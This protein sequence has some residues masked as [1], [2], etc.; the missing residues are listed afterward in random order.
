MLIKN[1]L[2]KVVLSV[3][4][5]LCH[6]KSYSIV[7]Y[8]PQSLRECVA[9]VYEKVGA[10]NSHQALAEL[11]AAIRENRMLTSDSVVSQGVQEALAI[12][13]SSKSSDHN[14]MAQYFEKLN[15][16]CDGNLYIF[17]EPTTRTM[18]YT[19]QNT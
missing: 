5:L 13:R 10:K 3:L 8:I 15:F 19:M 2:P 7:A 14:G 12:V 18:C 6:T 11:Y 4:L 9:A 16:W 17:I 1:N